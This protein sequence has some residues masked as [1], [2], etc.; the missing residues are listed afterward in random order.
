[1]ILIKV[2]KNAFYISKNF[3]ML[4]TTKRNSCHETGTFSKLF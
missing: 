4:F 1:M 2:L 3:S